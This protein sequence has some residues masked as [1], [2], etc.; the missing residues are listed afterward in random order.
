MASK[1]DFSIWAMASLAEVQPVTW[2][3]A[4]SRMAHFSLTTLLSSSTQRILAI[5]ET[6]V[7]TA[8]Y[9]LQSFCGSILALSNTQPMVLSKFFPNGFGLGEKVEIAR[10]TGFGI[11][12]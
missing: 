2:W 7:R 12:A 10:A 1:S 5:G 4:A 9:N 11:S 6:R 8:T 3:P